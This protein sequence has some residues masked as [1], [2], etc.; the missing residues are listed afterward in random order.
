MVYDPTLLDQLEALEPRAWQGTVWRHMFAEYPPD[1]PNTTGARW[2]PPGVAAI[3][4]SLDR[5]SAIAEGDHAVAMQPIRPRAKRTVYEV[6]VQVHAMVDLTDRE[7]L[8]AVGVDDDA[9]TAIPSRA[10]QA[11]GGAAAWLERDGLLI[12]SARADGANLVIF[13]DLQD[14]DAEFKVV[15]SETLGEG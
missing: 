12:P 8:R 10:C 6:H 15:T 11:V 4:T 3:Y 14:P 7:L 2:N 5:S 13:V 1:R 9:L